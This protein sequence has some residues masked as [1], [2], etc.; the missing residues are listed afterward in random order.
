MSAGNTQHRLSLLG[1]PK[2]IRDDIYRHVRNF[3]LPNLVLPRWMQ[4][5]QR[6]HEYTTG[7]PV[8]T[9]YLVVSSFTN[10]QLSNRQVY[11]E[12][13][14]IL[15]LDCQFSFNV[16]PRH[17]S[18]LDGCLLLGCPTPQ[19]QDKSYIHRIRKVVLKANWDGYDWAH[20]RG[21]LWTNW[22]D[23]T[24]M[25]CRELLGFSGLQKLTLDW[26]VP[27]PYEVLQPT[28]YQ[29]LSIAP[30]FERLLEKRPKM[31][32]EVLAWQII[33]GS[34]PSRHLEIRKPFQQY[35]KELLGPAQRPRHTPIC[36]RNAGYL[37]YQLPPTFPF[38]PRYPSFQWPSISSR[39]LQDHDGGPFRSR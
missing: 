3:D 37:S 8:A 38:E 35:T 18:F 36:Y 30:Y 6:W 26:K 22:E 5:M 24:F 28:K 7:Y 39:L 31:H 19:I 27:N 21:F 17:A 10:L 9:G 11:E 25:I 1:L 2:E 29:W 16:A 23:I 12:A 4:Q 14:H 33:A 20:I 34:V 13:S 32:M 15:Y